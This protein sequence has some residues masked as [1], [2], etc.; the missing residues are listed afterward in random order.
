[1]HVSQAPDVVAAFTDRGT[2][3]TRHVFLIASG[4]QTS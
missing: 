2:K 3:A 1:M 4:Y